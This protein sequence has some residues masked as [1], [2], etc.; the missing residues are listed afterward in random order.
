MSAPLWVVETAD[1]FWARAGVAGAYPRDLR[2]PIANGYPVAVVLLPRLEAGSL[3]SWL[4]GQEVVCDVGEP[5]R[6]LRACLVAAIGR[7][8]IFVDGADASDEQRFSVAHEMAHFL[9]DYWHPRHRAIAQLGSKITDV[10]DGS[11]PANLEERTAALLADVDLG[12]HLHL[13]ERDGVGT[14]RTARVAGAEEDADRLAFELLAPSDVVVRECAWMLDDQRFS[15]TRK[16][17]VDK[18]GL[19]PEQADRYATLLSPSRQPS[20]SLLDRLG[21]RG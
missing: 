14:P 19:P 20:T 11:R 3:E 18:F 15:A 2:Q 21:L 12:F 13:M 4:V 5:R 1:G 16:T 10:V 7:G 9:R 6:R 8:I 17:L